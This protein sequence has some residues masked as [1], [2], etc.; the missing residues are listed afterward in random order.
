M[1]RRNALSM[2]AAAAF[3]AVTL[4]AAPAANAADEAKPKKKGGATT[5]KVSKMDTT[6]KSFVVSNKKNGDFTVSFTDAT[7]FKKAGVGEGATPTD[8]TMADLKDGMRVLVKGKKDGT[9]VTADEV[10]IGGGAKKKKKQQ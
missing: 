3:A 2:F 8:A 4:F 6:A 7:K 10:M 9:K 5:G 1:T